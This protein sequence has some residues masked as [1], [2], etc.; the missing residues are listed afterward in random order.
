MFRSWRRAEIAGLCLIA[1]LGVLLAASA[2]QQISPAPPA[3]VYFAPGSPS[4]VALTFET[5]WSSEGLEEILRIL[6]EEDVRATFF[7]TGAWLKRHP[8]AAR[9]ILEQGHE[10][11][12]HTM[13]H[14]NLLYLTEEEIRHEIDGFIEA[15]QEILEY[16]PVL[17]RPPLGLYNGLVLQHAWK[18][19][20][21]TVLWSVESY[22]YLSRDAAEVTERVEGRLHGG[23]I[24]LF[25]AG[26]PVTRKALPQ[27]LEL[28]R[29]RGYSA[30]TV[31]ALFEDSGRSA[32]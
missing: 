1:L 11:G 23:A 17:F 12:N 14:A 19:R 10:I 8:E 32:R 27:I 26:S 3:A 20:C 5:F 4:K 22:D 21:R 2:L 13:N 16:R 29:R 28:L 18:K 9:A 30:V 15:A 6:Q 31:S 25:R 24:L 7:L